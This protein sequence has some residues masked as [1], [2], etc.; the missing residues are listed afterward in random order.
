MSVR[1]PKGH[2][3]RYASGR[4]KERELKKKKVYVAIVMFGSYQL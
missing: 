2:V 4:P 1:M 3:K